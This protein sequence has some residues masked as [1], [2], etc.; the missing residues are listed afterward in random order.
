MINLFVYFYSRF[1]WLRVNEAKLRLVFIHYS[2]CA[3]YYLDH[4]K[5]E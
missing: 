5:D 2:N 4:E 3:I 1:Q